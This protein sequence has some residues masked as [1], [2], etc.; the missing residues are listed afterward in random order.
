MSN[1]SPNTVVR[2]K[3]IFLNKYAVVILVFV[4]IFVFFGK[5][6]LILSVQSTHRVNELQKQVNDC[7]TK[8][9]NDKQKIFNLQS[10]DA[11]FEKIAREQYL[12]RKDSED[13]F[14]VK[15]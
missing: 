4:V 5:H 3:R 13:I 10:S 6:N 7:Q 15:E 14:I 12:M 1:I 11:N 2:L 8:I 9:A